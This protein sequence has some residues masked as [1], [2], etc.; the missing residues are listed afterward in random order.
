MSLA[1]F[2]P[3]AAQP[4]GELTEVGTQDY[5]SSRPR[6]IRTENGLAI[7]WVE[8]HEGVDGNRIYLQSFDCR[9]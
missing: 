3:E 8:P 1:A 2:D 4:V 7:V 9:R 5:L 6:L